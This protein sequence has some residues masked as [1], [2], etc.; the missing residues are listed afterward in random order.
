MEI[1]VSRP[2]NDKFFL[3]FNDILCSS[4][5]MSRQLSR[6]SKGEQTMA[7]KGENIYKRKDGRWEGR[8]LMQNKKY[9]SFYAKSY[10]EVR[11]KMKNAKPQEKSVP[12]LPT[13]CSNNAFG[14]FESW[15]N[16]ELAERLKPSTYESYYQCMHKYVLPHF[17]QPENEQLTDISVVRFVKQIKDNNGIS[18]SYQR[19]ILSIFKTALREISKE[20]PEY[21]SMITN[22]SLPTVKMQQEVPVFTMKEQRLIE[23]AVQCSVD[24][25][26]LGVIL[27]FYT[28]LRIG[29]LC[30][31]KWS[32]FD[33]DAGTMMVS[34]TVSRIQNFHSDGAKTR[35]SVG[36]PKS[37]TSLRRI[38]LPAFL[39]ELLQQYKLD[40]YDE[41]SSILSGKNE[42]F[43]PRIYQR[44]YK[45]LLKEAGVRDRKFHAIR[46]SF[47]TRAL[48]LG[49]DIKTLSEILG[50]SNVSITLNIYAHSLMEQKRIAI[51][52][53]NEMHRLHMQKP[54]FTVNSVV[55]PSG[56]SS[57]SA[58]I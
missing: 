53:F 40:S 29:E 58:D 6:Q 52:K 18:K 35:L 28:G 27:C 36:T 17:N 31:L 23:Y 3:K 32:D 33:M 46:H 8:V 45:K 57:K 14:L 55:I 9:Y 25:R 30:A 24:K 54:E 13:F 5:K 43:D 19:K 11:E 42:P 56:V 44:I 22:I 2:R 21:A 51:D 39:L 49:V 15:L 37:R 12:K 41:N 50:H 48:E 26:C 10:R 4:Q 16:S 1:G 20:N 38:P 34:R 47:A 7:R